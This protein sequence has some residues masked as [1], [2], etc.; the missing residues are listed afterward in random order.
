MSRITKAAKA[1]TPTGSLNLSRELLEQLIPGQVTRENF[2]EVFQQLKAA[3]IERILGG[4][5]TH[6]L[7]YAQGQDKPLGQPNHRNGASSKRVLTDGG[8]LDIAIP[9][10]R[11]GSYEPQLIG[12]H[13]RRLT[14]FDETIIAMYARGLTVRHRGLPRLHQ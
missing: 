12:K 6:H 10:D 1:A 13:E 4:E 3:V 5:L 8:A 7:G 2:S 11:A 9:R 14:G